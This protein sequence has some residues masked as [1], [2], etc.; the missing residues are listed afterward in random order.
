MRFV[1]RRTSSRDRGSR[2]SLPPHRLPSTPFTVPFTAPYAVTDK[3]FSGYAE[4][5]RI[6]WESDGGGRAQV[7]RE[8]CNGKNVNCMVANSMK[9]I[10]VVQKAT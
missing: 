7:T 5:L 9:A 8:H 2:R 10:V 3:S 4:M 1:S 6:R